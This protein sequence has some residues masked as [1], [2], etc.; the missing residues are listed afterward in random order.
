MNPDLPDIHEIWVYLSGSP[1]L[2]LVL[3]LAA[4]QIGI[5]VSERLGRHPLANPVAIAVLLVAAAITAI[6]MPYPKY[7][8]G[9]QFVHFL[10]G[11]A[12]VA[13]AV[14][15]YHGL[16]EL[17][18]R[19]VPLFAALLAGGATSIVSAVGI[20]RLLG[21]DDSIVGGF[22]A[23]SVTAP[24]AMGVAERIHASPTLTA[25]FA[26]STGILGA[27]L[28]RFVLDAVGSKAW[29]QRGFALGIAAHGIGTARAFS[30]NEEAGRFSGLAM[31]LHGILGALLIPLFV[32]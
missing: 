31:G 9:A 12:T 18:G 7:F 11:T 16:K 6:D 19:V 13:L 24:I 8:E 1:L 29:W 21:A 10:L 22:Y 2:A 20:A 14:P 17:R 5:V 25:V 26:V 28:G 15:I 23:K 27:A 3:T 4:Y 30:V 32:R